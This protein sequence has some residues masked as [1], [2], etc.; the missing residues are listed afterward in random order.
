[1]GSQPSTL[2]RLTDQKYGKY[3]K[4]LPSIFKSTVLAAIR[5]AEN[6]HQRPVYVVEIAA[7]WPA[8]TSLVP[9]IFVFTILTACY[10]LYQN[11]ELLADPPC[12]RFSLQASNQRSNTNTDSPYQLYSDRYV[13]CFSDYLIGNHLELRPK[14]GTPTINFAALKNFLLSKDLSL[15]GE[16]E[17][18]ISGKSK[19]LDSKISMMG[20]RVAFTSYPRTGNSFLRKILENITGVFTGSD[21]PL[22]ITM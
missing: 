4:N 9:Y 10:D 19:F 14:E 17:Y 7:S 1:M 22:W 20:N 11:D 16:Y 21:M 13:S 5:H 8:V 12:E 18:L 6:L 15:I 2:T 3:T